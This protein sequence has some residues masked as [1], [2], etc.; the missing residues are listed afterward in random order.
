MQNEQCAMAVIPKGLTNKVLCAVIKA[1]IYIGT[2]SGI[3]C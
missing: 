3:T 1:I 2:T